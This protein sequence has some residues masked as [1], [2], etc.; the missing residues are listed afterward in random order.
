MNLLRI[1]SSPYG[2]N[3]ISRMLT[4]EF[5]QRWLA[6]NP[7]GEVVSRNLS[8]S[9][10]PAVDP[11][12]VTANYTPEESRTHRQCE[13]L[14]FS[15]DL[16][17]ELT[18]ADEIVIGLPI[19]NWGPPAIFKLWVDQVITPATLSARPLEGKRATF[20]IAAGRNYG[21]GSPDSTRNFVTPWL[22]AVFGSLGASDMQDALADCTRRVHSGDLNRASFLAQHRDVID[23]L[24]NR[25]R[26]VIGV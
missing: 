11:A 17:R 2:E 7:E 13:I 4:E 5:V 6:A 14:K 25:E 8:A 21:P 10:I 9:A 23:G 12:W 15:A 26:S 18:D 19:H 16:I 1:D 24:F 22:R 20:L 3:A